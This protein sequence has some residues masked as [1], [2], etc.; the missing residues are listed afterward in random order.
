MD[1]ITSGII[2]AVISA[3]ITA[4]FSLM[5]FFI[6]ERS[7]KKAKQIEE[8]KLAF[9]NRPEFKIVKAKKYL[10]SVKSLNIKCDLSILIA[11][12]NH[13]SA[14]GF[15]EYD[16]SDFDFDKLSVVIYELQN[17]GKTD[18]SVF[19]AISPN[20]KSYCIIDAKK[21]KWFFDSKLLKYNAV[22]DRKIRVGESFKLKIYYNN[23]KIGNSIIVANLSLGMIDCNGSCW[24]QPLFI[25]NDNVYDSYNVS[26][27]DY[28][29]LL[30]TN[31]ALKCFKDPY[32][33]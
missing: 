30:N 18:I 13:V 15:V 4:L 24:L 8:Y 1:N 9:E 3:I 19:D 14:A 25:A 33:W 6:K 32:L 20:Q 2:G 28:N 10:S 5:I 26:G 16:E 29:A 11:G 31:N 12:I 23:H 7:T 21:A 22:Y 27:K 17:V